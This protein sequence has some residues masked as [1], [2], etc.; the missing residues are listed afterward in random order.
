MGSLTMAVPGAEIDSKLSNL[1]F[2]QVSVCKIARPSIVMVCASSVLRTGHEFNSFRAWE[3]NQLNHTWAQL[4]GHVTY[5]TLEYLAF[6]VF[7]LFF[8]RGRYSKSYA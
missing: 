3:P 2:F 7:I 5:C 1:Q 4:R 6:G 8:S